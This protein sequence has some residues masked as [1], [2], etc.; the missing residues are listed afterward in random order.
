MSEKQEQQHGRALL[1][2]SLAAFASAASARL[3]DPMLPDLSRTFNATPS[4]A[5][6]VVAGFLVAYGALQVFFGPLGDR[7][8]KY[9]TIALT[10][11]ACTLGSLACALASSL[12]MLVLARVLAGATA[13]GII[14]LS[15]AWIGDTVPYAQRQ[16][17][18][19]RFLSG[20]VLGVVC[21]Q[22]VGGAVSDL[23]G[24]RWAFAFLAALYLVVGA[25]VWREAQTNPITRPSA[26]SSPSQR[27]LIAQV[28]G[29]LQVRWARA[30]LL[31]V[32]IE[33]MLVFGALAFVPSY[34]HRQFG[35][36][37]TLAGSIM[38]SFGA[39]GLS[40]IVLSRVLV[41]R[42]GEVKLV[43]TGGLV[44]AF[45]WC[46]LIA[47]PNWAWAVPAGF[48]AGL[49]YYMLHNTLQTNATQMVPHL[50]GT[51]VSMFASSFFLGQSLGV[52]LAALT[53]D[54]WGPRSPF[55]IAAC[56]T[57]VVSTVFAR[58]LKRRHAQQPSQQV[59]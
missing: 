53:I 29:V 54:H 25:L 5:A 1:L 50:R 43:Q 55:I 18:L 45:A 56:L 42:L 57:P 23:L 59:A 4:A 11:L 35:L 48:L 27:D 22:F 38:T 36:S 49:G 47:G 51:A 6:H 21:G 32:F 10:T 9:R 58:M 34:V 30:L 7:W 39:G 2:L 31:I 40:Y 3:C 26:T 44:I 8:G 16:T 41:S 15:M 46:L 28:K 37:L 12:N 14:P 13:G 52:S 17:T 20:Q 33:G 19:A 24:W